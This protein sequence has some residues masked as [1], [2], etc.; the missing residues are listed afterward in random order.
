LPDDRSLWPSYLSGG[1]LPVPNTPANANAKAQQPL[2][3]NA[4]REDSSGEDEPKDRDSGYSSG[5]P[6][7]LSAS[8]L[9]AASIMS[10]P[11]S[12]NM[13]QMTSATNVFDP[14]ALTHAI[15]Y[16]SF[17]SSGVH[18]S[19][20]ATTNEQE[21]LSGRG[22]GRTPFSGAASF[23]GA[24][25]LPYPTT[26]TISTR[27]RSRSSTRPPSATFSPPPPFRAASARHR[28][29]RTSSSISSSYTRSSVRGDDEEDEDEEDEG[30]IDIDDSLR[31][32]VYSTRMTPNSSLPGSFGGAYAYSQGGA[33]TDN[34][35]DLQFGV[36]DEKDERDGG[37]E[38]GDGEDTV[39]EE[40]E[41]DGAGMEIDS[42]DL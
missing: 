42:M 4:K 35:E 37:D 11:A 3:S 6:A 10:S 25:T 33:L 23:G 12:T 7:G 21:S 31:S 28:H 19:T 17:S 8:S 15:P 32:S 9:T 26:T 22:S 34:S 2:S 27:S 5:G 30:Y 18:R 1:L 14:S 20:T 24:R 16:G 36:L 13:L 29:S 40:S 41:G 39:D 38:E